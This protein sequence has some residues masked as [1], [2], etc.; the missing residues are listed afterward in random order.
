[1]DKKF[2]Q[3]YYVNNSTRATSWDKPFKERNMILIIPQQN[4]NNFII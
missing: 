3:M 2:G 4:K 1:M